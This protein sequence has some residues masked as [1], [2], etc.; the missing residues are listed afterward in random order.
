MNK[1]TK[2]HIVICVNKIEYNQ[3]KIIAQQQEMDVDEFIM[4]AIE[5]SVKRIMNGQEEK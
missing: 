3:L 1:I 4:D 2:K 5:K